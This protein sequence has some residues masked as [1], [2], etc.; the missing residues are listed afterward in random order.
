[1]EMEKE[2]RRQAGKAPLLY[3]AQIEE[4]KLLADHAVNLQPEPRSYGCRGRR[5]G[6]VVRSHKDLAATVSLATNIFPDLAELIFF[7]PFLLTA[8][9]VRVFIFNGSWRLLWLMYLPARN[10]RRGNRI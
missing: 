9:G 6:Q 4:E 10:T 5:P 1:M 2:W 8:C 3:W 7:L